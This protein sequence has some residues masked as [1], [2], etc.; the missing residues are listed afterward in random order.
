MSAKARK[1][2]KR[3]QIED[4]QRQIKSTQESIGRIRDAKKSKS[5]SIAKQIERLR[6]ERTMADNS[7]LRKRQLNGIEM[8]SPG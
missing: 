1:D 6:N 3:R 7:S 4:I 5:A 8:R 2:A